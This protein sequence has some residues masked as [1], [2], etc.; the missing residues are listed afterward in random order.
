VLLVAGVAALGF[1]RGWF[2]FGMTHDPQGDQEKAEFGI[3]RNKINSDIHKVKK[4]LGGE[5]I[6][7]GE[8]RQGQ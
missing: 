4:N 7:A 3:N 2:N 1:Y 6:P 8:K 5:N